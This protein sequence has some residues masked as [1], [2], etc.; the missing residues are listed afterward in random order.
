MHAKL[1]ARCWEQNTTPNKRL[2]L[3]SFTIT[4]KTSQS[5][6]VHK[7]KHSSPRIHIILQ[8]NL[9]DHSSHPPSSINQ[10]TTNKWRMNL[11]AEARFCVLCF[12]N[13]TMFHFV[14][15]VGHFGTSWETFC[16]S[17]GPSLHHMIF[18]AAS[19][20]Y[21][22]CPR[23]FCFVLFSFFFF[24]WKKKQL[25][26]HWEP[27]TFFFLFTFP[28][29]YRSNWPLTTLP[30]KTWWKKTFLLKQKCN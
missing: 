19:A 5:I 18:T 26:V 28:N 21:F 3:P 7:Q 8:L 30:I 14:P 20:K 25:A 24:S 1:Q 13:C 9:K 6:Q 15:N 16:S 27:S 22:L 4:L 12:I 29:T 23:K 11:L 10:K 2:V 17:P